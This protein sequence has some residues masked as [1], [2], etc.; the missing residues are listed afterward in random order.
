M[1][2]PPND[3]SNELPA[4]DPS[5]PETSEVPETSSLADPSFPLDSAP[6]E[7]P[8]DVVDPNKKKKRKKSLLR[9]WT[10]AFLFAFLVVMIIRIFFFETFSIPS[11][12]MEGTLHAGD[13]IVVNKL[14]YG[15]RM[16][17]TLLSIPF[18]HQSISSMPSFLDWIQLPYMRIPGYADMKH[19]DVVVFNFPAE[20]KFPVDGKAQ[21]Y[22][23]DHRTHFVKR[24]AGLPGD[25]FELRDGM[26]W[27]NGKALDVPKLLMFDYVVKVD[28]AIR[29]T[30]LLRQLGM[31]QEIRKGDHWTYTAY[32]RKTFADSLKKNPKI[33][34]VDPAVDKPGFYDDGVFPNDAIYAWNPDNYGPVVIPKKGQT[35][36]I[37]ADSLSLYRRII[38]NYEHNDLMVRNDS[39]FLNGKYAST[40]TF[41]MNY[42]FMLGDNRHNSFDSRY[43]GFVPE[44]HIVGRAAFIIF[45]YDHDK[46][47]VRWDRCFKS[48]E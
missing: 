31:T 33:V 12:S 5:L 3:D 21:L 6:G 37:S 18:T 34:S 43:W 22:P 13:Y 36:R 38:V 17:I 46:G 28:T 39:I 35:V 16:P 24:L 42:Y 44:D 26:A 25:T 7:T 19:G 15:P 9:E 27:A 47:G 11:S 30:H 48:V 32:L 20:D 2:I 29:D 8:E 4:D 14:A 45:S 10:E 40:Y 23:V 1:T 41:K